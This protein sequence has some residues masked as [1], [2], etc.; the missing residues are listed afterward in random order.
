MLEGPIFF[1]SKGKAEDTSKQ[2]IKRP[3]TG[4]RGMKIIADNFCPDRENRYPTPFF[5]LKI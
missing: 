4:K 5:F 2:C 3:T 1:F